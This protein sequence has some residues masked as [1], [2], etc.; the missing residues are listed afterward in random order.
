MSAVEPRVIVAG[1]SKRYVKY[2]DAPLLLTSALRM[3]G[4]TSR[5]PLW[6]LRD[7]DFTVEGGE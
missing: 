3:R 5:S 1:V 6:A 7:V 2:D 4:R